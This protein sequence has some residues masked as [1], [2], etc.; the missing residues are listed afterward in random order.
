MD[1]EP[2]A[3]EPQHS[4]LSTQYFRRALRLRCPV[5]GEGRLFAGWTMH[6]LCPACGFPFDREPGYWTNAVTLNFLLTGGASMMLVG[7]LAYSGLP[8][9]VIIAIGLMLSAL[10]PLL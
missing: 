8:V 3:D 7:P 9:L 5:C 6:A 4:A 10:P 2:E 1:D